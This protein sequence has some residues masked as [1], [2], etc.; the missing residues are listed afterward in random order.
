M[1]RWKTLVGTNSF[2]ALARASAIAAVGL[3]GALG[4][5]CSS[6]SY[7]SVAYEQ[8]EPLPE[9]PPPPPPPVVV[10]EVRYERVEPR[11]HVVRE[12]V[13]V[14]PR[15]AR[16]VEVHHHHDRWHDRHSKRGHRGGGD[17]DHHDK[18]SGR[19][20]GGRRSATVRGEVVTEAR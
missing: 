10:T 18:P 7:T 9:P 16:V 13:Y 19:P 15:R 8:Y 20:S 1:L 5:G 2:R 3:C 17:D 11:Y 4:A 14:P 12:R 6:P